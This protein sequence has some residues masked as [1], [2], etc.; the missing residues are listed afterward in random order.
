MPHGH[1]DR[2]TL[3]A[4]LERLFHGDDAHWDQAEYEALADGACKDVDPDERGR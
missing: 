3:D 2:S 1:R 4:D